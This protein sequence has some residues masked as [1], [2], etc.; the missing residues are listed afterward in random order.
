M[1]VGAVTV[2]GHGANAQAYMMDLCALGA[3]PVN[4]DALERDG[5]AELNLSP[6]VDYQEAR[7]LATD[8]TQSLMSDQDYYDLKAFSYLPRG[9]T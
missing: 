7:R 3:S 1:S 5:Y 9:Y 8:I 6:E 2:Y 4:G